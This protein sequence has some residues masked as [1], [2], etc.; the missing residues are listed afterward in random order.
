MQLSTLCDF[1]D[2]ITHLGQV[3]YDPC[4]VPELT[5]CVRNS[6]LYFLTAYPELSCIIATACTITTEVPGEE[7]TE[8]AM[9]T[10]E[11][12]A[13]KVLVGPALVLLIALL[14]MLI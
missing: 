8:E 13:I 7:S 6:K 1:P 11:G 2:C 3:V 4:G 14:P 12:G 10:T 5:D 9:A